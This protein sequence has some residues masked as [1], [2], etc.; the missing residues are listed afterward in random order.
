MSMPNSIRPQLALAVAVP[1][2]LLVAE[3]TQL[4]FAQSLGEGQRLVVFPPYHALAAAAITLLSVG[5]SA[6]WA[7]KAALRTD[8][9][10][11]FRS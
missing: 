7:T 11:V 3:V 2:F 10:I 6:I 8:P 1:L 5:V 9:A 4:L